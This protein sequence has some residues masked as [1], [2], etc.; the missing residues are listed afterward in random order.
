MRYGSKW[1]R[2]FYMNIHLFQHCLLKRL[3]LSIEFC[4]C[5]FVGKSVDFFIC[6]ILFLDSIPLRLFLCMPIPHCL[7]YWI[8]VISFDSGRISL[9]I[10]LFFKVVLVI[11]GTLHSC[12]NF[13]MYMSIPTKKH[14]AILGLCYICRAIWRECYLNIIECFDPYTGISIYLDLIYFFSEMF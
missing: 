6:V 9:L 12:M 10:L 8:F 13:R 14:T 1:K 3:I 4:Y 2:I 5:T 7:G 11:L